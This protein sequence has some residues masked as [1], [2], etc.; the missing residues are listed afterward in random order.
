MSRRACWFSAV[1]A[2]LAGFMGGT[3]ADRLSTP[4]PV[5]AQQEIQ[6]GKVIEAQEFRLLDK[7]GKAV[8]R[9]TVQGGGILAEIPDFSGWTIRF[10]KGIRAEE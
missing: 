3:V 7:D 5:F 6:I 10:V 4:E 2:M 9:L 8:A 1:V